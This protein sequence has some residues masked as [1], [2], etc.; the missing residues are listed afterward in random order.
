MRSQAIVSRFVG[1][2][3]HVTAIH[4]GFIIMTTTRPVVLILGANGWL[5]LAAAKAFD[6]AGWHALAQVRRAAMVGMPTRARLVHAPVND[7]Q[8][9]SAQGAGAQVIGTG[10]RGC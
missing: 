3:T 5:G 1:P 10:A 9:L 4:Q 2:E 8:A 7:L 6:A